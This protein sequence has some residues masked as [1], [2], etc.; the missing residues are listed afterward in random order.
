MS[1]AACS[2]CFRGALW[3]ECR[4]CHSNFTYMIRHSPSYLSEDG[5]GML[6]TAAD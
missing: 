5:L 2:Y 1:Q 6:E 4:A 3:K